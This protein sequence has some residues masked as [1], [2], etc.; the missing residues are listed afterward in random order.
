MKFI[1]MKDLKLLVF[2]KNKLQMNLKFKMEQIERK[3][4]EKRSRIR[5][6]TKQSSHSVESII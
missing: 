3:K 1:E 6:T 4:T 5:Q 2:E